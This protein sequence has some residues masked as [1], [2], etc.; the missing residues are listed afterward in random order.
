MPPGP[1][2][3]VSICSGQGRDILGVLRDHPRRDDVFVPMIEQDRRNADF[4]RESAR[5]TA[6]T[7][8]TVVV[9]DAGDSRS[10]VGITR[11]SLVIMVG[12]LTHISDDDLG[13]LVAFLPQVS[14]AHG[15]ALWC[16]GSQHVELPARM[17]T[18]LARADFVPLAVACAGDPRWNI[19]IERFEGSPQTLDT[20][21]RLF[22]VRTSITPHTSR[23]QRHVARCRVR[24]RR[25]MAAIR[26]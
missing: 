6:L 5:E 10:Y 20:G 2:T 3:V 14:A 8:A 23:L 26:N 13:R 17:R 4:A 24:F 25:W 21:V 12:F 9:G 22:T 15:V 19:G 11:A 16:G 1:I 7:H 18:L